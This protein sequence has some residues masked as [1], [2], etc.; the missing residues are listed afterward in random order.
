MPVPAGVIPGYIVVT[1]I[2][3]QLQ[4]TQR[5]GAAGLNMAAY[6]P[7]P[8]TE[9]LVTIQKA[10]QN[11][12]QVNGLHDPPPGLQSGRYRPGLPGSGAPSGHSAVWSRA[13]GV[14][15]TAVTDA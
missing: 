15:A 10:G 12:L 3:V 14:P 6:L 8:G 11:T 4:S 9:L 13:S 1:V 2:A 7:L 5:G